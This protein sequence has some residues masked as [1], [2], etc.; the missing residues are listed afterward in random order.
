MIVD[1][2]TG[3]REEEPKDDVAEGE[4]K[5]KKKSKKPQKKKESDHEFLMK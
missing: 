2:A 1:E 3:A 5:K 4:G